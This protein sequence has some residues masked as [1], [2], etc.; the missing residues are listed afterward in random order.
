MLESD[1]LLIPSV[2]HDEINE[3]TFL[4]SFV[5]DTVY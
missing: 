4:N 2:Y 3:D 1:F 5:T